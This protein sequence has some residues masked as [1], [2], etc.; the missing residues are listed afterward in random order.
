MLVVSMF[1]AH[2]GYT[3][4]GVPQGGGDFS[5][6]KGMSYFYDM[7]TFSID[8]AP[9]ELSAVFLLITL[10]SVFI[11]VSTVLPGGG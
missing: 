11:I 10:L 1:G 9:A 6:I 4:D 7:T 5:I 2:F 8:G 3:V